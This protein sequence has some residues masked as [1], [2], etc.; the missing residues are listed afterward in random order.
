MADHNL[1]TLPGAD[2]GT[3]HSLLIAD[4]KIKLKRTKRAKQIPTYDVEN[5]GLAFAEEVKNRFNGL[6]LADREPEELWS[7]IRDIVK[8]TATKGWKK[9]KGRKSRS[10]H[11]TKR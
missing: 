7:D 2:C 4:V 10:G 11:L 9:P 1:L 5:I 8:E 6:Q 3:D